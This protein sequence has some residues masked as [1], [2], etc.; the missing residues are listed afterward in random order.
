MQ[1]K[2]MQFQSLLMALVA[3]VLLVHAGTVKAA[4]PKARVDKKL[5]RLFNRLKSL[6]ALCSFFTM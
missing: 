6:V 4:A 5:R 2:S 1:K 3:T